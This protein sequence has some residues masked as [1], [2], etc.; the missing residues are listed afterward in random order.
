MRYIFFTSYLILCTIA[1][2]GAY[3]HGFGVTLDKAVGDYIVDVDY[4]A[5]GGGIY[6]GNPIQFT[7]RL[8][9]KDRSKQIEFSNVRVNITSTSENAF[10]RPVFDGGIASWSAFAPSSMTFAFPDAGSY[11]LTLRYHQGDITLVE[12]AFPF[13]VLPNEDIA[14]QTGFFRFTSDVAKGGLAILA[15]WLIVEF[16]RRILRKKEMT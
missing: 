8:F 5:A 4:D 3:A 2:N 16:G 6:A 9:N 15:L 10:A 11:T 12:A 13:D 14:G 1:I 7:F